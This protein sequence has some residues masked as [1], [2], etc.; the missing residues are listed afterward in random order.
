MKQGISTDANSMPSVL[1][2]LPSF[3]STAQCRKYVTTESRNYSASR[4]AEQARS[5]PSQMPVIASLAFRQGSTREGA[6]CVCFCLNLRPSLH[7][8]TPQE[9]RRKAV[10]ARPGW[11]HVRETRPLECRSMHCKLDMV[12][13]IYSAVGS[14]S[15]LYSYSFILMKEPVSNQEAE[16]CTSHSIKVRVPRLASAHHVVVED[17]GRWWLVE[18]D[19]GLK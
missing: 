4:I 9:Q 19:L 8:Q 15:S 3:Q 14:V 17:M 12:R 16:S 7:L 5:V 10:E 1:D 13:F 2:F 18:L 11:L 6:T